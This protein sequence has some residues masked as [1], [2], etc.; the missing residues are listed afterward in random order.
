MVDILFLLELFRGRDFM[1]HLV[2]VV[3]MCI[4]CVMLSGSMKQIEKVN[5]CKSAEYLP[6]LQQL[7]SDMNDPQGRTILKFQHKLLFG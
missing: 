4:I 5:A 1:R 7:T 6:E 2:A 3:V